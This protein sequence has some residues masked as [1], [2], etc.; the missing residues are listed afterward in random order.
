MSLTSP[1]SVDQ[2]MSWH[3]TLNVLKDLGFSQ[4]SVST[5]IYRK[6]MRRGR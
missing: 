6:L 3:T 1:V 2:C 5:K 4:V